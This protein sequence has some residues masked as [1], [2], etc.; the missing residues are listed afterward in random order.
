MDSSKGY[1]LCTL[2][3]TEA[4]HNSLPTFHT[5]PS[6]MPRHVLQFLSRITAVCFSPLCNI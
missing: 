6:G 1:S 5:A 2:D 3:K 4:F